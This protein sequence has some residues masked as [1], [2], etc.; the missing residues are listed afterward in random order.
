MFYGL[1]ISQSD[2]KKAGPY[3]LPIIMYC[4]ALYCIMLP[5]NNVLYCIVL[6]YIALYCIVKTI[7]FQEQNLEIQKID[8]NSKNPRVL[9]KNLFYWRKSV[10]EVICHV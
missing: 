6:H 7:G 1:A 10:D 3:Q 8:M 2:C 4:I 9:R 5:C